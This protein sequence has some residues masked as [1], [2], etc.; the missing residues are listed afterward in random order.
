[1]SRVTSLASLAIPGAGGGDPYLAEAAGVIAD[2]ARA[3]AA[4]WSRQ[5]PESIGVVTSGMVATIA[6]TAPN[7]RPAELRLMHPLFGN[8]GYWYPPPGRP[9]LGPAADA[10]SDEAM[11][12]YA[13]KIDA[14]AA[15]AGFR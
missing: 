9:F 6:A 14:M 2:G 11:V 12:R 8:R 15:K 3:M 13:K 7:A 10:L 5:I 4:T 1:V